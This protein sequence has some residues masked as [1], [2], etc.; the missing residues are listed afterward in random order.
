MTPIENKNNIYV[1]LHHK[2]S[3]LGQILE[4]ELR[5][6]LERALKELSKNVKLLKIGPYLTKL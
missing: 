2:I 4:I 5:Y 1:T 3:R 6:M